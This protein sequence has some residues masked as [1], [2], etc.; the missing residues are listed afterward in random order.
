MFHGRQ[1]WRLEPAR[2]CASGKPASPQARKP[3]SLEARKPGSLEAWK[4]GSLE[5]WKPGS[6]RIRLALCASSAMVRQRERGSLRA[7]FPGA[8]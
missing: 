6:L 5:A 2:W 3:A 4:P 7:G 8:R 1:R